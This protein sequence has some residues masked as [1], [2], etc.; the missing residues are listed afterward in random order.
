M[1][2]KIAVAPG[3]HI[4]PEIVA[5][6][7][8]VLKAVS[9]KFGHEFELNYVD[10]GGVAID[11]YGVSC[12]EESL[13]VCRQ[14]DAVLFGAAGGPKWEYPKVKEDANTGILNLRK[15][16]GLFANLRPVKVFPSMVKCSP[17]K[18][19]LVSGVDLIVLRENTGGL[20]FAPPKKIWQ[21]D[22]ERM[23]VDTMLYSEHEIERIHRV[24]FE[25]ARSRRKKL[26]SVDKANV[27]QV[28]KLWRLIAKEVAS[29]Y[30][31]VELEHAYVDACSMWLLKQPRDYDVVVMSNMF[32]DI[33][34]DEASILAG[35][36]GMVG[37]AQLAGFSNT[38]ETM[39][40]VYES[41]HGSAPKHTG[42]NDVNPIA[43]IISVSYMLRYSYGLV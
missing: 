9:K 34:S 28:G 14:C 43:T 5:E 18:P 35:S 8:K 2:G 12:P 19:E 4:G 38:G 30:P 26:C 20:Y 13:K 25:L 27:L 39:F 3:D 42:K 37:S 7:I 31:D 32:G 1:K 10:I 6:G 36:L 40:G 24:G 15:E 22:K 23:A 29:E 11:K 21:T 41:S 16:F 17:L 33:L